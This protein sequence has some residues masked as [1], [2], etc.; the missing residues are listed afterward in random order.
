MSEKIAIATLAGPAEDAAYIAAEPEATR[1]KVAEAIAALRDGVSETRAN[2]RT[3][4]YQC[5]DG[6]RAFTM[7]PETEEISV[8]RSVVLP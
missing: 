4:L 8:W 7:D 1:S 3:A 6:E 2:G 5:R